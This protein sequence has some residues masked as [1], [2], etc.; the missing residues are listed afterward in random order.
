MPALYRLNGRRVNRAWAHQ[1]SMKAEHA[2]FG[3]A[4]IVRADA[5]V[6]DW[7]APRIERATI[8]RKDWL[9]TPIPRQER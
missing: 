1:A 7:T 6:Y 9:G 2:A 5:V 8:R 3:L 4:F